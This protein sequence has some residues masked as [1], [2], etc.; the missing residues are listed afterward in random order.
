MD[1]FEGRITSCGFSSGDR[2]VI[3]SWKKSPFGIFADIMWAKSDGTKVLIAPN[4]EIGNYISSMYNFDIIKIEEIKLEETQNMI[5]LETE[6]INCYFEWNKGIPFIIKKRPL[7][8]VASIEYFFGWLMF[9]T[10]THGKTK[11]GKEEWYVVDRLSK[12]TLAKAFIGDKNLGEFTDFYPKANFGFSDPP[13]MPSSV[14]V[15][16]HIK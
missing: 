3:G 9:R 12:L 10:K 14:L 16:S 13:K 1:I 5:K 11:D 2:L 4:K 8:F 6:D 15:R 7:W